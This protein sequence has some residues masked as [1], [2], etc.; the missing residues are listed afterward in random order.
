MRG[1]QSASLAVRFAR[2]KEFRVRQT[3]PEPACNKA[4]AADP[5]RIHCAT[6]DDLGLEA[7]VS[8]HE[9][10][11]LSQFRAEHSRIHN[12]LPHTT[13]RRMEWPFGLR[14]AA[15]AGNEILNGILVRRL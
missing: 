6:F 7:C 4:R 3:T 13:N 14:S 11:R 8:V 9:P 10:H 2:K 15:E 1:V 5:G 12:L